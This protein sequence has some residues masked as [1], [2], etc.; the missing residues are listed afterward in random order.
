MKNKDGTTITR[1][2]INGNLWRYIGIIAGIIA[3][4]A[5]LISSIRT[6]AKVE[7]IVQ[8]NTITLENQDKKIDVVVGK[9]NLLEKN[10][11]EEVVRSKT[12]DEYH[13]RMYSEMKEDLK[14]I[15]KILLNLS[16]KK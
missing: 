5:T 14:E 10:V 7:F 16:R 13:D 11:A 8:Q 6:Y 4:S 15:K 1:Q 9:V 12:I 3:I 2:R